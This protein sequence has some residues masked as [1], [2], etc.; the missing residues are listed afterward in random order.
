M[1]T[2]LVSEVLA[3]I[4]N[5]LN[6]PN[7]TTWTEAQLIGYINDAMRQLVLVRPDANSIVEAITLV[8]GTKQ[9]VPTTRR[10][11][12]NL[13]RNMGVDGATPGAAIWP[14]DKESL[15][16]FNPDWHQD[17]A[18]VAIENF[19]LDEDYPSIYYVAPPVHASTVV[20][21]EA[22]FSVNPTL[23]TASGDTMTVDDIY[24][25]SILAWALYRAY[26][27]ETESITS[28]QKARGHRVEF[29][30]SLGLKAQVDT[31][32]SPSKEGEVRIG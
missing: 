9:T 27:V 21:V 23:V 5:E 32:T 3:D 2:I 17:T 11:L 31:G 25:S 26:M 22:A 7:Y 18:V 14:T 12:L 8:P 4:T 1:A 28:T 15:D 16:S 10:R 6:D 29:Y 20:Q 24:K 19:I 13:I 30:Q